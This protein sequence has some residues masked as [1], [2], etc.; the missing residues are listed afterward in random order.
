MPKTN[1][2]APANNT[3]GT[4]SPIMV[5]SFFVKHSIVANRV[6]WFMTTAKKNRLHSRQKKLNWRI[7]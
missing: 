6:L 7:K 1:A 4:N 5:L 3:I 2:N